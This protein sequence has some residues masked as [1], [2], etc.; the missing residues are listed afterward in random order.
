MPIDH[1]VGIAERALGLVGVNFRLHGRNPD[2]GLD[3]VGVVAQ[4]LGGDSI[5]I[6]RDYALRGDYLERIAAFM[7]RGGCRAMSEERVRSGDIL[8]CRPAER[9]LHFA[10]ATADGFVHAHAGLRRVVMTPR[11]LPWPTVGHWRSI[12]D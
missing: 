4:A 11:P 5:E 7:D 8:L 12:G 3:C 6:P 10:I 9:Q 2:A 1:G